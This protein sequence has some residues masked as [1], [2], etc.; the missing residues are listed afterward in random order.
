[1]IGQGVS[2]VRVHIKNTRL[3]SFIEMT[4]L[5]HKSGSYG[6]EVHIRQ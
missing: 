3:P 6:Q 1:M 2:G 4:Q 5:C